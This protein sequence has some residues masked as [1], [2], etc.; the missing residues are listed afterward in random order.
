[1]SSC[2][3]TVVLS[4]LCLFPCT[5]KVVVKEY[6]DLLNMQQGKTYVIKGTVDLMGHE[7]TI[8]AEC[9]FSFKGGAI[10]NK[11]GFVSPERRYEAPTV[12]RPPQM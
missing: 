9:E 6:N 3:Q 11:I 5:G 2:L 7:I 10:E 8:P 12:A 1:M 4:L